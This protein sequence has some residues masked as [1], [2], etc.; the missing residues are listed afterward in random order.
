[1]D[2]R[3]SAKLVFYSLQQ[4]KLSELGALIGGFDKASIP[5][6]KPVRTPSPGVANFARL[7]N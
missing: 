6:S 1:V 3:K 4:E 7:S 5:Q 2:T